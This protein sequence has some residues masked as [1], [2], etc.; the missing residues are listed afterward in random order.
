MKQLC[1]HVCVCTCVFT[2]PCHSDKRPPPLSLWSKHAS[3]DWT[4]KSWATGYKHKEKKQQSK[5]MSEVKTRERREGISLQC[6]GVFWGGRESVCGC[7]LE[8]VIWQGLCLYWHHSLLLLCSCACLRQLLHDTKLSSPFCPLRLLFLHI[9]TFKFVTFDR[10]KSSEWNCL[11]DPL[12]TK[13]YEK[14]F[15]VIKLCFFCADQVHKFLKRDISSKKKN[16]AET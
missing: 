11:F 2:W 6:L 1:V 12:E 9:Q 10:L 3:A 15:Y 5:W 4:G 8:G 16:W 13:N 7:V 14:E